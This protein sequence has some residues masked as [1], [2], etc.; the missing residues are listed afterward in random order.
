MGQKSEKYKVINAEAFKK[1]LLYKLFTLFWPIVFYRL[2]MCFPRKLI[3]DNYT[4]KFYFIDSFYDV[5][6]YCYC[7]I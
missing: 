1:I 4:K 5:L 7:N 3:I 2:Y 6:V